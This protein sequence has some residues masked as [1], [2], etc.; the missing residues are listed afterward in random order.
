VYA[1]MSILVALPALLIPIIAQGRCLG[2]CQCWLSVWGLFL[3][4]LL[5]TARGFS[6]QAVRLIMSRVGRDLAVK[7]GLRSKVSRTLEEESLRQKSD[8]R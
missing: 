3:P 5:R 4:G 7:R 1:H 2:W 6:P 8:G